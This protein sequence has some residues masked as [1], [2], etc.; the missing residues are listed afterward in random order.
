MKSLIEGAK[1][2][3]IP[4]E[5][6]NENLI[7]E[8]ESLTEIPNDIT[9]EFIEKLKKFWADEGIQQTFQRQNEFQL[10]DSTE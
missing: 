8:L 1:K 10:F 7:K 4:F 6:K 5:N 3:H 2:L 9:E